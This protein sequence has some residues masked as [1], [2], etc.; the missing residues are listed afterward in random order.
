MMSFKVKGLKEFEKE[1]K[2]LQKNVEKLGGE[3][4]VP[5]SDLFTLSFMQKFTEFESFDDFLSAGNFKVDSQED[6]EA[7]PDEDMDRHVSETTSFDSWQEMLDT[8]GEKYLTKKLG[9]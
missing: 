7:I 3:H 6:F 5:L 8:A 4:Q 1:L 9:F 2:K